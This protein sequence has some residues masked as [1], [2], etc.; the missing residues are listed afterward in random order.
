MP[1]TSRRAFVAQSAALLTTAKSL[2]SY[3]A[4]KASNLG[5]QLYTVRNVIGK[6]PAATLAAIK[7]I[8]YTEVERIA[9]RNL[10]SAEANWPATR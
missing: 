7:Q 8:G 6:D 2:L 4:L 3:E 1:C 5:V 10:A 9:R